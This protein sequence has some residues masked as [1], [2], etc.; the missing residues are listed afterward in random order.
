[1]CKIQLVEV[2]ING[3]KESY[4]LALHTLWNVAISAF[5]KRT[6]RQ[7]SIKRASSVAL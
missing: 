7:F 6:V 4:S 5:Q 3:A 2:G 1:M